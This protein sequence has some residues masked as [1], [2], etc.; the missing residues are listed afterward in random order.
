MDYQVKIVNGNTK[1]CLSRSNK[2]KAMQDIKHWHSLGNDSFEVF[3]SGI[4]TYKGPAEKV[5]AEM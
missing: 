4:V 2:T 1:T 3:V 5:L